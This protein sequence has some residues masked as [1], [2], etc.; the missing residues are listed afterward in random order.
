MSKSR[1]IAILFSMLPLL[2]AFCEQTVSAEEP[3][4]AEKLF[5]LKVHP[6]LRERCFS[7]H[8]QSPD[9]IEGGLDL[10]SLKKLKSGGEAFGAGILDLKTPQNS[11]LYRVVA[12]REQDYAMPPK[13]SEQLTEQQTWWIKDW[14]AGGA[15]WPDDKRLA[16]ISNRYAEGIQWQTRGGQS[17]QWTNRRYQPEDL[18]AWQ[19]LSTEQPASSGGLHAVDHW[20][21]QK[22]QAAGI[23]SAPL[24]DRRTLIRRATYD[25]L[26]VPPDPADVEAFVADSR[27]D[28]V[29]WEDLVQQLLNDPRYGEQWGR[30]WLDVVRYADSSGFANDWERPNAWRYRDY[31]IR[32]FN[33]D[34]PY[35]Q[36]IREQ[37][38]GDELAER[39]TEVPEDSDRRA[40]LLIA[41]G[42]LRMGPWEQTGMSVAK[43]TRQQYLDD[44]TDTVG[45]VFLGQALQCCRCHDHKFDP[46]PTQDYYAFQAIFATTQ[47]AEVDAQ[48]LAEENRNGMEADRSAK[49]RKSAANQAL[50]N[51]LAKVRAENEREW[52]R[53]RN[54]PW[55]SRKEAQQAGAAP[56]Q[57]PT[58]NLL[59][60]P[61]EFGQDRIARKWQRKF[62]WE[63]DRYKPI[64]FTVYS[65]KTVLVNQVS[66]R[67]PK[68]QQPTKAGQLEQTAV[69]NGGDLFS[70]GAAVQPAVLSAV[71]GGGEYQIP[72]EISGRRTALA[73]WLVHPSNPL[74][75]RVMVNRIWQ[76][77]FGRGL[78]GNPNNFGAT[79]KKP[80]HP[81]LLDWLA[82]EFVDHGWS[83]KHLHKVLMMS[84][85]Y[86]RTS[87]HP[88]AAKMVEHDPENQLY[89]YFQPR[90]LA[91]EELRDAMLTVSNEL[92]PEMGGIP[93]R[94][95][96]NLEAAL[97]PRM[98]MGTFAPGYEPN[99]Q[100]RDRN[101]RTVYA[102]KLRGLRDPFLETFNQPGSETSC[103]LRD[104]STISPQALTLMNSDETADRALAF[105]ADVLKKTDSAQ[106]AVRVIFQRAY[107]RNPT[108]DELA[109]TIRFWHD[110]ESVQSK[111]TF[112]PREYPTEIIRKASE[113]NTGQPFTFREQLFGYEDYVHDLQPH[114]TDA[115]T[116]AMAD[117]CLAILNSNEF[118]F[119]Y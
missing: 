3:T 48:W 76:W 79:G 115:R 104:S 59:T 100:P 82:T 33:N 15:P 64:A 41:A 62:A 106:Q 23:Q 2:L 42:F 6:L 107:G 70:R 47:F 109:V 90:R 88:E 16:E 34:V 31:V 17:E 21:E 28:E 25:L 75:A 36:F 37:I 58:R 45:Q 83:I 103:E 20:I 89:A 111:L 57:L 39:F 105:A 67:R 99:P 54:L 102:L 44:V 63:M 91:A 84:E 22:Q 43:V 19:P 24:A 86:R 5:A 56:D 108:A 14:I 73:D 9:S 12:K 65:G 72:S 114:E 98:I 27:S 30:H 11:I 112:A 96:M 81:E 26:G 113:E 8:G 32:A 80:T 61:S 110:Q 71:P 46:L 29:A 74:T 66:E 87:Q 49:Q 94:P 95:D 7:C 117:V 101:R 116:R 68:P 78:A 93:V 50:L 119:V 55:S 77:H 13:E 118:A 4:D 52:F 10:T 38:A 18:W 35:D 1:Q 40:E 51:Q 69:L 97:Q 85:T 92:N 53:E 60:T